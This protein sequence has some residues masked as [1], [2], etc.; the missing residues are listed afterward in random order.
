MMLALQ[1]DGVITTSFDHKPIALNVEELYKQCFNLYFER[2]YHYA[3]TIV[4]END[5][6][7]D[8]VQA[9]FIKLWEKRNGID[10]ENS[11]KS[12]LY[13]SVYNLSLNTIRNRNSREGHHQ[14]MRPVEFISEPNS[15]EQKEI[16]K[17]IN[18]E[19]E[20]L[21]ERCREV[22]YKSRMEGKKYAQIAEEM[23]ISVKTVEGQIGKALKILRENLSDLAT[24]FIIYFLI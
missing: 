22:F 7:K 4:K 17:R 12:Y 24:I 2:L 13:T 19:I 18:E 5:A 1:T 21:P 14:Q 20:K 15:A 10:L 8:I 9:A 23:D 16:R 11:A 6:A 3:Y